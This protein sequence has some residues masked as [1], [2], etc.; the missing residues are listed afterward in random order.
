ML[1][2]REEWQLAVQEGMPP[3]ERFSE[4]NRAITARYARWYLDYPEKFK[5]A[6]MAA[7]ASRQVGIA[8]VSS[9]LLLA[10]E[11]LGESNPLTWLHRMASGMFMVQDL[12]E[13][14][15]GNNRIFSD[16]AWAHAAYLAGGIEEIEGNAVGTDRDQLLEGFRLIDLGVKQAA[17]CREGDEALRLVWQGN[18][19]LLRHE[20]TVVLQPVFDRLSPGGCVLASF[21]SELDFSGAF[22]SDPRCIASFS[23]FHGYMETLSGMRSI[24][25][26]GHRWKWIELC[27]MPAWME[28]DRR[29]QMDPA[30]RRKLISMASS[31]PGALQRIA[32]FTGSLMPGT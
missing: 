23:S 11:R 15:A 5:W 1:R 18:Q 22:P 21:G 10:P 19:A 28:A 27:V 9:E 24:A 32:E 16:I 6:G 25:D 12:E 3:E 8:V 20:Q 17:S 31:E 7:F 26:A 2:T 29:M 13:M 30:L 14:R 4:R